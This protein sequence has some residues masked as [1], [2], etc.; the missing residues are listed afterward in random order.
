MVGPRRL[1]GPHHSAQKST[2][3]GVPAWST[4]DSKLTS[5]KVCTLSAAIRFSLGHC[6]IVYFDVLAGRTVPG[7]ILGHTG[8]L[9]GVPRLTV[10]KD[11]QCP[12][13]RCE[14]RSRR[15]IVEQKSIRP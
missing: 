1:Q 14:K 15:V 7:M 5:V 12:A 3:T 8:H 10:P 9:K 13:E 6:P 11:P 4:V 2:S